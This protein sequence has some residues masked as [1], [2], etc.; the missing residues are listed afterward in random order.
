MRSRIEHLSRKLHK[1]WVPKWFDAFDDQELGGFFERV[2]HSFKP[3]DVGR[4]RLVT[5]CRQ[6]A[7]YAHASTVK[8]GQNYIQKLSPKFDFL[9]DHYLTSTQGAWRFSTHNDGTPQDNTLDLY[10]HSFVIFTL[11]HLHL[12][13]KACHHEDLR[14]QKLAKDTL[15][16]IKENFENDSTPGLAEALSPDLKILPKIRRQDPHMHMLEACIFAYEIWQDHDYLSM[17]DDMIDLF[18]MYF[19][20]GQDIDLIEFFDA[21]LNVHPNDGH[22]VKPGHYFEGVWLIQKY[23]AIGHA[24][25]VKHDKY[26]RHLANKL[27]IKG[28]KHGYD[29]EYGGIYDLCDH[30]GQV[31]QDTK[32]LWPF[33][34][35][36]KAN[37][38]M[39][40]QW[41]DRDELKDRMDAMIHIF[42]NGYIDA[43]GFWTETLH[44]DLSPATDYMPGTT[45][46]HL[47]FGIVETLNYL[48][49]RGPSKSLKSLP[50]GLFYALRRQL[51]VSVQSL[52]K[53]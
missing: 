14:P 18:M 23:L 16:F 19:A 20:T 53:S 30:Q 5:Q 28:N 51:S 29:L 7:V 41:H 46:Y 12:G 45:P 24:H 11:C 32:R 49:S 1:R 35:A 8:G 2:G 40:D 4:K 38:L 10:G 37:A 50:L 15:Y 43:R 31:I 21:N 44:R 3:L 25:A 52:F 17:A 26:L 34:E 42:E 27:L 13:Q 6:L 36:L 9:I 47:Y 48:Q 39:L 22:T 33:A